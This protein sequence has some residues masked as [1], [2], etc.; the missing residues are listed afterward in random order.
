MHQHLPSIE[1]CFQ[2]DNVGHGKAI[3]RKINSI[4]WWL[5]IQAAPWNNNEI[6]NSHL[7]VLWIWW[8]LVHLVMFVPHKSMREYFLDLFTILHA[9]HVY[10]WSLCLNIWVLCTWRIFLMFNEFIITSFI[11]IRK[12]T[13]FYFH[14]F[15]YSTT[16][17]KL[18]RN[19]RIG[20]A[21]IHR[22]TSK[23]SYYT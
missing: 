12:M 11:C 6:Y 2:L 13:S 16:K 14:H 21:L 20:N 4:M 1:S 5:D 15:H 7:L 10:K 3:N 17:A 8:T 9:L 23:I 19:D 18:F 22:K